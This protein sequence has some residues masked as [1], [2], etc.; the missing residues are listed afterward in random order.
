MVIDRR[1]TELAAVRGSDDDHPLA[2]PMIPSSRAFRK[3]ATAAAE[4]GQ[5]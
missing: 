1:L 4:F 3:P 2:G 5:M